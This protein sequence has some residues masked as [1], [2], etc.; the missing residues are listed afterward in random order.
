[1]TQHLGSDT[2]LVAAKAEFDPALTAVEISATI[3]SI[4]VSM[5]D[6]VPS[7]KII[8]IE[9]DVFDESRSH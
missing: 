3:D 2:L 7:A 4:E 5:R 8:F 1:H 6:V 9:P